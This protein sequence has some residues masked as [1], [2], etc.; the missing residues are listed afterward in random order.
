VADDAMPARPTIEEREQRLIDLVVSLAKSLRD[1]RERLAARLAEVEHELSILSSKLQAQA[2][3][4][5]VTHVA[6][7]PSRRNHRPRAPLRGVSS[8]S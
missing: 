6:A 1:E 2:A 5:A 7:L 8:A 4:P 3:P